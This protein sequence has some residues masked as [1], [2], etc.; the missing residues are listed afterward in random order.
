MKK[1]FRLLFLENIINRRTAVFHILVLPLLYFMYYSICD[2][3]TSLTF[4]AYVV[5]ILILGTMLIGYQTCVREERNDCKDVMFITSNRYTMVIARLLAA[6]LFVSVL[7][8]GVLV[9]ILVFAH[10]QGTKKWIVDEAILYWALYYW[11]VGIISVLFGQILGFFGRNKLSY[12]IMLLLSVSIGPLG[13]EFV[14]LIATILHIKCL[15]TFAAA[16]TIGQYDAYQGFNYLY[17]FEIESKRFYHRLMYICILYLIFNLIYIIKR[18]KH[19]SKCIIQIGVFGIL[20]T[21]TFCLYNNPDFCRKT[22]IME[23]TAQSIYDVE[24]YE[25]RKID[26]PGEYKILSM[27]LDVNLFKTLK[28]YTEQEIEIE[29]NTNEL[30]MTLYHDLKVD[31]VYLDDEKAQFT[32]KDDVITVISDKYLLKGDRM[33]LS[34]QYGGISSQ[35]YFAGEKATYLPGYFAWVPYPGKHCAMELVNGHLRTIP[36]DSDSEIEYTLQCVS[37]KDI[38][39]NLDENNGVYSGS[40]RY[41]VTLISG[42]LESVNVNGI[43]V[44]YTADKNEEFIKGYIPRLIDNV[45][46]ASELL[47]LAP[48][49]VRN[50]FLIPTK[51]EQVGKYA[52]N[53]TVLGD[54][55]ISGIYDV[56]AEFKDEYLCDEAL[57]GL[58]AISLDM[59][60]LDNDAQNNLFETIQVAFQD[61]SDMSGILNSLNEGEIKDGH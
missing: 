57:I 12:L 32:Q 17:G 1:L 61:G 11:L 13:K 22:G 38:Y 49:D 43:N 34:I 27:D 46:R 56:G 18:K 37:G 16:I 41:G 35:Y 48:T 44:F 10:F 54:T 29:Q 14:E 21:I 45:E 39:C 59:S 9:F 47:S 50:V 8:L 24:Y 40:S 36:L 4:S 25:N 42:N 28:V 58:L 19:I 53:S 26:K 33:T 3:I 20:A 30:N 15:R 6:L 31:S 55:L 7:C 51:S 2:G 23:D 60:G 5:Q 52:G